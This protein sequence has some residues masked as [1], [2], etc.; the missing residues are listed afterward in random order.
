[1]KNW[2][3]DDGEGECSASDDLA[4]AEAVCSHLDLRLRTVNFSTEYWDRVFEPF[5]AMAAAGRTPNP[6]VW[7]NQEI[8]FGEL[9]R[10]A[11][12]LGVSRIATGH[13]ARDRR[14]RGSVPP[15]QGAGSGEGPV[16]LPLP[17]RPARARP[18]PLS[19]WRADQGGGPRDG[20]G[21]RP[22]ESRPAGQH[23]DLLHRRAAVPRVSRPVD[24]ALPGTRR[25]GGRRADRDA[26]RPRLPHARTAA[27]A[28][29]RRP[30]RGKRR[31]VVRCREGPGRATFSSSPRAR[32]TPGSRHGSSPREVRAG[33]QESL[34]RFPSS[35]R[36]S[37]AI[38]A[39]GRRAGSLHSARVVCGSS[40]TLRSGGWPPV[41]PS[42]ST[43][44][45]NASAGRSS[46]R[47][48]RRDER[49]ARKSHRL[50][51]RGRGDAAVTGRTD[52]KSASR[53]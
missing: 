16:V 5:L 22:S 17:G 37:P 52:R 29:H 33:S 11:D 41:S 27:R 34:P 53:C 14:A 38:E 48:R 2:E 36:R 43:P 47:P 21:G 26:R 13:Y 6:D 23:R 44:A 10:Y 20:R 31:A 50:S 12:D 51:S 25:D 8:K 1:M 28:R 42:S 18:G 39:R 45:R 32:P 7:C 46:K 4:E 30:P 35:A 24:P 3:E 15:A 40:S 19:P 9:F 49:L